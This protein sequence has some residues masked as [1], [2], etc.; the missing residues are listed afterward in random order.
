MKLLRSYSR[1]W[2][3]TVRWWAGG[4]RGGPVQHSR[5]AAAKQGGSPRLSLR[6][7]VVEKRRCIRPDCFMC[8]LCNNYNTPVNSKRSPGKARVS[9][10]RHGPEPTP[11]APGTERPAPI[12]PS[13]PK[14]RRSPVESGGSSYSAPV[15]SYHWLA[16]ECR[17]STLFSEG[18][19]VQCV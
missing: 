4:R 12:R 18:Y 7:S 8:R 17:G 19:C 2:R 5:K 9:L 6:E 10:C 13:A 14:G 1:T 16:C 3:R 11:A 15:G